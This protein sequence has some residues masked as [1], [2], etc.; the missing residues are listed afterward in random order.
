MNAIQTSEKADQ[1]MG[2]MLLFFIALMMTLSSLFLLVFSG[3]QTFEG[4]TGVAW[5][6][7]NAVFPTVA[8][9]FEIMQ[10][11]GLATTV[12]VGLFSLAVIYFAFRVGQRWAWFVMWILPASMLPGTI[13]LARTPNQAVIAVFGAALILIAIAGLLLSYR[14]FFPKGVVP[15]EGP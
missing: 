1:N 4:D 8:T 12:S 7:L 2:W 6:D 3:P 13:A 9:Q 11:S 10:Q 14:T 5:E 15:R